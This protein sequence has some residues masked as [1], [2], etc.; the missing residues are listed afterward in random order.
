[1]SLGASQAARWQAT[2]T[3]AWMGAS[4]WWTVIKFTLIAWVLLTIG[5][6]WYGT[7]RDS[8]QLHHRYFWGWILCG[9]FTDI[10]ILNI[11]GAHMIVPLD[12]HWYPLPYAAAGL[13]GANYYKVSF[14]LWFSHYCKYTASVPAAFG[15]LTLLIRLNRDSDGSDAEHLRGLRLMR[16]RR[17]NHQLNGGWRSKIGRG[18]HR[19][20]FKDPP[21]WTPIKLGSS[22]IPREK[23]CE[24]FL[25]TGSPGG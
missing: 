24:H 4:I 5:V 16:P 13:N 12:G 23:D 2:Q 18:L 25:I 7:G 11:L 10:P 3:R 8:P 9:I 21:S 6:I 14:G 1:M 20:V 22:I 15:L 17:H 19:I